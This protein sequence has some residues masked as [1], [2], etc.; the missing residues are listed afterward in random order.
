MILIVSATENEILDIKLKFKENKN[1]KFLVT[2]V[3]ILR[4]S[5]IC[6][7]FLHQDKATTAKSNK[8]SPSQ[9]SQKSITQDN[10]SFLNIALSLNI[11]P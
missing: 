3:G 4:S 7:S 2:G 1:I 8:K 6:L 9:A 10:L 11:S 5:F